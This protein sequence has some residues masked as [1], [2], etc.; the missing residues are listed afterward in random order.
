[1]IQA[2][3]KAPLNLQH[4]SLKSNKS[5]ITFQ[6][7][8]NGLLVIST[9][10]THVLRFITSSQTIMWKMMKTCS[11]LITL[12]SF[13]GG[14]YTPPG[15]YKTWHIGVRVKSSKKLVAFITG[16]PARIRVR[17]DVVSMA[18]VN[19]LCVHKKLRSK[20]LAPVMIK[21]VTRRVHLENIWQ[22]AYTAGWFFPHQ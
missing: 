11:G 6:T 5:P 12:K 13:C 1:M 2:Y 10:K 22:A 17:T 9:L 15:Y 7:S 16:I 4:P 20:R 19:F 14:P 18:E 8:M 21:E 3:P